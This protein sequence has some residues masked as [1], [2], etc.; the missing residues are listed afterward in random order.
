MIITPNSKKN[1]FS[2]F[3]GGSK[4]Q[5]NQVNGLFL[6][7]P[8][9][10]L[11]DVFATLSKIAKIWWQHLESP[12]CSTNEKVLKWPSSSKKHAELFRFQNPFHSCIFCFISTF[13]C[14][15]FFFWKIRKIFFIGCEERLTRRRDVLRV[16]SSFLESCHVSVNACFRLP[17]C[18]FF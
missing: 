12:R 8:L 14:S 4:L 15:F 9:I 16:K 3:I 5:S 1:N 6:P 2:T 13:S 18:V 7:V 11:P 10:F 17:M